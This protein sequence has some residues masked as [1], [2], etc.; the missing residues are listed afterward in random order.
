MSNITKYFYVFCHRFRESY[1]ITIYRSVIGY[2]SRL[3]SYK[4]V[5]YILT[6]K[7]IIFRQN[8]K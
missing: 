2:S 5:L 7:I 3:I 8:D 4:T 1:S 6:A